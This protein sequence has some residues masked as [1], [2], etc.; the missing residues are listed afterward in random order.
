MG[1]QEE[2]T[3]GQA[4]AGGPSEVV[5]CRKGRPGCSW[6]VRQQLVDRVTHRTTQGSSSGK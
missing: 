6:P 2:R 4:A 5:D 3:R 1:S